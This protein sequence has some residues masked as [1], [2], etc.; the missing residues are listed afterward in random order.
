[1]KIFKC[2]VVL[3]GLVGA[4]NACGGTKSGDNAGTGGA[5]VP[6]AGGSVV[7][8]GGGTAAPGAGGTGTGSTVAVGGGGTGTGG[9]VTGAGGMGTG[10]DPGAGGTTPPAG[11]SCGMP[12][13]NATVG[14]ACK[15]TPAPGIKLTMIAMGLQSPTFVTQAPGDATR[16]YVLEQAGT[17]RVVKDGVLSPT[18]LLDLKGLSG[19][20][21]I[22]SAGIAGIYTETGLLGMAFDPNFATNKRFVLN[23]TKGAAA[24]TSII[25][26]TLSDPDK[27]DVNSGK[28]LL[29]VMQVS[30]Y[31]HKGGMVAFGKD[32]CLYI[33]M[34]DG[35][36]EDDSPQMTGQGTAD[37]LS[38]ML[39]VD[40]DKYP[41]PAP[42]NLKDH[43]WS[44]GLR[45]PYRFSF[46]RMTGDMYIGDVGQG[47]VM[48]F[49]EVDIEPAGV[50][51][52]NYGW[53]IA[54]GKTGCSG[55]CSMMTKP[56]IDYPT[57]G[58]ANSVIGGYVYRGS[59]MPE[60]VGRYIYADWTERKIKTL[61]YKGETAGQPDICDA[62]DTGV[63]VTEKVR[64]FG[65]DNAGEIYLVAAGSGGGTAG[66]TLTLP[67]KLYRIDP[68]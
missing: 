44:T 27:I 31:N 59:K 54:Q 33:G 18:P 32:G 47:P 4:L 53:S 9:A 42:G 3:V 5:A 14:N 51:G 66:A 25:S 39:R 12:V 20:G 1:M 28:E 6:G 16:L 63:T 56:A 35:G 26:Y 48:G 41:T 38:V 58:G 13:K 60:M 45:N 50:S 29:S 62:G 19:A 17:V 49:E 15:G 65:E 61:I 34:G 10:G 64:G 37:Q 36:N 11:M 40:V 23:Y 57:T 21:A 55:D 7:P 24:N 2:S 46:D 67:G 8:G 30:N 43:I 68:Q 52:R 22:G